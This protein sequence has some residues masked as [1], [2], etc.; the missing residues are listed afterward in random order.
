MRRFG[1]TCQRLASEKMPYTSFDESIGRIVTRPKS[2][3]FDAALRASLIRDVP[4]PDA[5]G[6]ITGRGDL[7]RL[8]S[9]A[10]LA[11]PK[12]AKRRAGL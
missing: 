2:S 12:G 8:K 11:N 3:L 5:L 9:E 6:E 10:C 7:A 4:R 1:P